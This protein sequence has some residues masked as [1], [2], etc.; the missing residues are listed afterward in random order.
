M[1]NSKSKGKS[2]KTK[3]SQQPSESLNT[4]NKD[5]PE[6]DQEK[7]ER[8]A[9]K[10]VATK[11]KIKTTLLNKIAE[12]NKKID[13]WIE[14]EKFDQS[15]LGSLVH[16]EL[17]NIEL[18]NA[19][20]LSR[21]TAYMIPEMKNLKEIT[22]MNCKLA[23]IPT[24]L[25][26]GTLE[27]I[28]MPEN[29]I[30]EIPQFIK[31]IRNLYN[32]NL[33]FNRIEEIPP[34]LVECKNLTTL[35]LNRNV[36]Y[37]I[38]EG[39]F[40][41]LDNLKEL[42]LVSNKLTSLDFKLEELPELEFLSIS[43]NFIEE[44][45]SKFYS[46]NSQIRNLRIS[47][48]PLRFIGYGI[49]QLQMLSKFDLRGTHVKK[50]PSDIW[51]CKSMD[52]LMLDG[53]LLEY[54]PMPVVVRGIEAMFEYCR[55]NDAKIE[56]RQA[57]TKLRFDGTGIGLSGTGLE[58]NKSEPSEHSQEESSHEEEIKE[59][60][61][62]ELETEINSVLETENK[63]KPADYEE[64]KAKG[65]DSLFTSD[66]PYC[67]KEQVL[68]F[69]EE[70]PDANKVYLSLVSLLNY[71]KSYLDCENRREG[72]EIAATTPYFIGRIGNYNSC[73]A[74]M[75]HI[76]FKFI[77]KPFKGMYYIINNKTSKGKQVKNVYKELEEYVSNLQNFI[78][79]R[80]FLPDFRFF[81]KD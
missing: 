30:K 54:P 20:I 81:Y 1:G 55:D 11:M 28:N 72:I 56:T 8:I 33:E 53:V 61:E 26:H 80:Q 64:D 47:N 5:I 15:S 75:K 35:N 17:N 41:G 66:K 32:L 38:Q 2:K 14:L 63:R 31:N 9:A 3:L 76:G 13:G 39:S 58:Q 12:S 57:K 52:K 59:E 50:L 27:S 19:K 46:S 34:Y 29:L 62:S 49:G 43:Y 44:I 68:K 16:F 45:P 48:S 7:V 6:T 78:Q 79:R 36:I 69:H 74:L 71:L 65:Y 70:E 23:E 77:Q 40:A 4:S 25:P 67:L 22:I 24:N 21:V 42:K 37:D 18:N 73:I 51:R 10:N 60:E